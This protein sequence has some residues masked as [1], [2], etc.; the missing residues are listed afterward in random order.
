MGNGIGDLLQK[1]VGGKLHHRRMTENTLSQFLWT[2]LPSEGLFRLF[3]LQILQVF[4]KE[5]LKA[6]IADGPGME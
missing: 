4:H 2:R 6:G 3:F 5:R 1:T